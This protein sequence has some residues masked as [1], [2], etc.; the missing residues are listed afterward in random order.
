MSVN[1]AKYSVKT[2]A[3]K[4]AFSL[5]QYHFI[6]WCRVVKTTRLLETLQ[7]KADLKSGACLLSFFFLLIFSPFIG[8]ITYFQIFKLHRI[9]ILTCCFL[10]FNIYYLFLKNFI[11]VYNLSSFWLLQT[12]CFFFFFVESNRYLN[13]HSGAPFPQWQRWGQLTGHFLYFFFIFFPL[14]E[15]RFFHYVL[16]KI[17]PSLLL[18]VSSLFSFS[19]IH[20]LFV[21]Y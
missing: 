12:V 14:V 1:I 15:N 19:C 8:L 4:V 11:D 5:N 6:H 21:S 7:S 18:P 16:I 9:K 2:Q 10:E 17:F 20:F 3:V 13:F